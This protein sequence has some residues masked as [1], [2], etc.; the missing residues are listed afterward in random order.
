MVLNNHTQVHIESYGR[1]KKEI[2]D[3]KQ[4]VGELEF[5]ASCYRYMRDSTHEERN[6]LQHY[7]SDALDAIL[8]KTLEDS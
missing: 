1:L 6:R 7:S 5:Q 8:A 3:L 4:L 2:S